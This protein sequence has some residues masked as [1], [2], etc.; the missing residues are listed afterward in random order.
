MTDDRGGEVP[1]PR[2]ELHAAPPFLTWRVIYATVVGAL[3]I[4][5][6]VYAVLTAVYR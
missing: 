4:Q 2:G 5:V 3:A 6:I 1:E